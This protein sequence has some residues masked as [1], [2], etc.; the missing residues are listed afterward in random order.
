MWKGTWK[1]RPFKAGDFV[2]VFEKNLVKST[3][4]LLSV[5]QLDHFELAF[6]AQRQFLLVATK[7]K[8]PAPTTLPKL[9]KPLQDEMQKIEGNRNPPLF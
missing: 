3:I 1:C 6:K 8:A 9:L 2:V 7:A 5:H 4:C